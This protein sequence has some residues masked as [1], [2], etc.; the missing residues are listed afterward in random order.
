MHLLFFAVLPKVIWWFHAS[1]GGLL[2][3]GLGGQLSGEGSSGPP[4]RCRLQQGLLVVPDSRG[5]RQG[6]S[7]RLEDGVA[8]PAPRV[9]SLG[10]HRSL[11][12]VD[13]TI[14]TLEMRKLRFRGGTLLT[15]VTRAGFEPS[16]VS[17][18]GNSGSLPRKTYWR[19][20]S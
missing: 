14:P 10:P 13:G 17:P 11:G 20:A 3:L 16:S 1:R 15:Q 7:P 18:Q 12:E 9:V 4:P 8:V 19:M 5:A 2:S 6:S